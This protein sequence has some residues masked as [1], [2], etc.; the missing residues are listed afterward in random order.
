MLRLDLIDQTTM[1]LC[2][3]RHSLTMYSVSYILL[4]DICFVCGQ[5]MFYLLTYPEQT[6]N[7]EPPQKECA[8]II[9]NKS[10]R[11]VRT[12]PLGFKHVYVCDRDGLPPPMP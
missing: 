3:Y 2:I 1:T 9:I 7:E 6:V 11:I 5:L 8:A 4:C 12:N 10:N